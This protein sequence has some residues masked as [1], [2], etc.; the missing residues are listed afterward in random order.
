[1]RRALLISL[2]PIALLARPGLPADSAQGKKLYD[3]NC[4]KCHSTDVF[5]RQDRKIKSLPAL[6]ERVGACMHA[7][8]V[9]LTDDEQ[10]SIVQYL[11]EEFYKF[12]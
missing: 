8:Q 4:T 2:L 11:N 12:K 7:A 6:N 10:K 5:T 9:T 3:A 1:M